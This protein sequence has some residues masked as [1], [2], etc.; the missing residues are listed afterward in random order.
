MRREFVNKFG[1]VS[2]AVKP[3]VLRYFYHDLTGDSSGSETSSQKELDDRVKQM[4]EME[5]PDIVAD[6]RHINSGAQSNMT[7]FGKNVARFWS[8]KS[9]QQ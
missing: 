4:I 3:A 2:S 8:N 9:A 6:L 5:D 1:R 7:T